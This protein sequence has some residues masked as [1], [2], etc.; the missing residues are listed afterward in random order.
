MRKLPRKVFLCWNIFV[1]FLCLFS[2]LITYK[3]IFANK[4]IRKTEKILSYSLK[5]VMKRNGLLLYKIYPFIR[6]FGRV[7]FVCFLGCFFVVVVV[8][9]AVLKQKRGGRGKK[10]KKKIPLESILLTLAPAKESRARGLL[11]CSELN[12]EGN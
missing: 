6:F 8:Y 11:S 10:N 2:T 9:F 4:R 12:K 3:T 5:P 7:L 1:I